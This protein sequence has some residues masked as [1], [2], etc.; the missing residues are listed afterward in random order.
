MLK[1]YG[2]DKMKK[3]L[4]VCLILSILALL[5]CSANNDITTSIYEKH[6]QQV[7]FVEEYY[8]ITDNLGISNNAKLQNFILSTNTNGEITNMQF[9]LLYKNKS[10]TNITKVILSTN[11]N[12]YELHPRK[13]AQV[14]QYDSLIN[15]NDFFKT[16]TELDKTQIVP[17][18]NFDSYS[19]YFSGKMDSD[20]SSRDNRY[21][22]KDN[23]VA[24]ITQND[25][26]IEGYHIDSS[27]WKQIHE[28]RFYFDYKIIKKTK[29]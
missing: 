26:I 20:A 15:A 18:G 2:V 10:S 16:F 7:D 11:D 9:E 24:P 17:N 13:I 14:P 12:I 3:S 28:H 21:I 8:K 1:W 5:A 27:G 29:Y 23:K 6:L 22:I 25:V 19:Y 4:L